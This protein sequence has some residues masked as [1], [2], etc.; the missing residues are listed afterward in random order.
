MGKLLR[1]FVTDQ[2]H[3]DALTEKH[4][5]EYKRNYEKSCELQEELEKK[6]NDNEK[7]LLDELMDAMFT[8]GACYAEEKFIRGFRL[9]VLMMIEV[10]EGQNEFLGRSD[11]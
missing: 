8:N 2:L 5:S 3:V 4:S 1:A 9:G 11:E 7:E 6:L 10:F